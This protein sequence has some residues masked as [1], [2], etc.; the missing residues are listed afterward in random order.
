MREI[1]LD[2]ETTGI[3]VTRHRVCDI[4]LV[5]LVD[6]MPTGKTWQRYVNPLQKSDR[7][8][9]AVHRL[10]DEMLARQPVFAAIADEFLAFIGDALIVAHNAKFDVAFINADLLACGRPVIDKDRVVDTLPI[11]RKV[12]P[13]AKADL[14]SLRRYYEVKTER[15]QHS[16]LTDAK[17]L[18][19]VYLGLKGGRQKSLDVAVETKTRVLP[20]ISPAEWQPRLVQPSA[21]E[22]AAHAA[23]IATIPDAIW[24][25]RT[26]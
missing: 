1:V 16:A 20:G 9:F 26:V 6:G 5:E 10:S 15:K 17:I 3:D 18:A 22:A 23:F 12:R 4:G 21:E 8:A 14:D 2:I 19:E 25:R 7:E 13:G 24:N 11:A